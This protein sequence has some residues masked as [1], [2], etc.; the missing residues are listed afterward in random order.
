MK[1][2][3]I[4]AL[5]SVLLVIIFS[6]TN[7][8]IGGN[9]TY[10]FL[11]LTSSARIAAMGGDFLT[12]NDNDITLV[13]S[14]P[15]LINPN[16]SQKLG[17]AYVDFFSDVNYGFATYARSFNNVGSFAAS[18]KYINYG[19]FDYAT[20]TGER[21]GQ[22]NAGETA[23][24]IGWGRQLDS[25]FSIGANLKFIYSSLESYNS[26][27]MAVD[28][29][30]SYISRDRNFTISLIAKNIGRQITAYEGGNIEP[31]P[32]ELQIGLA[33]RLNHLPFRY[34]ILY[35]HIEKWD[36]RYD[37]PA[38]NQTDPISGEVVKDSG[39]EV[40]ADNLMRHIVFGGELLIGKYISLRGGYNYKRRQEMKVTTKPGTV[41]FSWGIGIR[42][43]KFQFS[44]AR[45]AY[46]LVGSPNYITLTTNLSDFF[47][48]K[49]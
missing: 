20:V 6:T 34:S 35:N 12:I 42:I 38:Q 10:E 14:N 30:G 49:N 17:I 31:L 47:V 45:S 39:I 2:K 41:G 26:F 1:S 28:V 18:M 13:E 43:S 19:K 22:F 9:N 27:G 37:D 15:S 44:Y 16:M 7:A 5:F 46:H 48:K 23:L 4:Y 33:K 21:N 25:L 40:F 32:F 11:N 36:L 3:L 29:A 24:N 8:Q